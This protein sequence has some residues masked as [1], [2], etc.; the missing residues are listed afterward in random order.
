M[1]LYVLNHET[2]EYGG[3]R[4]IGIYASPMESYDGSKKWWKEQCDDDE[5]YDE[6]WA[7]FECHEYEIGKT[8]SKYI[9]SWSSKS[10]KKPLIS[11]FDAKLEAQKKLDD[12]QEMIEG[13]RQKKLMEKWDKELLGDL[14]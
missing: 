12:E 5:D 4:I 7:S 3:E 2:D 1:K 13:R 9:S 6:R 11:I 10:F 8:D 14:I